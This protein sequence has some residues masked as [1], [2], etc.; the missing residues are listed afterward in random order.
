M[1][2][3][4]ENIGIPIAEFRSDYSRSGGPGG[5]NVNKV[6]SKVQL[7]WRPADNTSLPEGVRIRLLRMLAARLTKDGD[8]LLTSQ[9]TRDQS[10]NLAD[11]LGKVRDLVQI[12]VNPPR[13]RRPTF[14]TAASQRRRVEA[15][16]RHSASK[17]LRKTPDLET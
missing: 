7:R 16:Q 14:P 10:R 5:Q 11:C 6:N 9:R 2:K 17:K 1:L 12:A 3:I 4:N 8:L 15:K 13:A